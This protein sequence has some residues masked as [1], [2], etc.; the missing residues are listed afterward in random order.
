MEMLQRILAFLRRLLIVPRAYTPVALAQQALARWGDPMRALKRLL[1]ESNPSTL[2]LE[3]ACVLWGQCTL[4]YTPAHV[5]LLGDLLQHLPVAARAGVFC[6]AVDNDPV[7]L[8]TLLVSLAPLHLEGL[9]ALATTLK[10]Q[11]DRQQ[12]ND[13]L[14]LAFYQITPSYGIPLSEAVTSQMRIFLARA[15]YQSIEAL[16]R[17]FFAQNS[18]PPA[19]LFWTYITL[20]PPM[21]RSPKKQIA[22][23]RY[24]LQHYPVDHRIDQ[25]WQRLG[26][27]YMYEVGDY[28]EALHA[29]YKAEEHGAVVLQLQ[30]YRTGNWDALPALRQHPSDAFPPIVV[31]DLEVDPKPGAA[32]GTRVFEVAAVRYKG[33]TNLEEYHSYIHHDFLPAKWDKE[34]ATSRL[35]YA[36]SVETVAQ[37][38]RFFIGTAIVVGHNIQGFDALE[39]EAMGVTI[40]KEQMLDTLTLARWLHPDSLHHHLGLLCQFYHIPVEENSLHSALPDARV[41]ARLF[42]ALGESFVQRGAGFLTGIR[43]LVTPG[44]AFDRA[45]LQPRQ[46][47]ADPSL[48]WELDPRPVLP[49]SSPPC[50]ET[51]PV[52]RCRRPSNTR[53][54]RSSNTSISIWATISFFLHGSARS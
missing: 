30:S 49:A 12:C 23:L 47:P 20:A 33:R 10:E 29:Y 24:F 6:L 31:I 54:M 37:Q 32:K 52:P 21:A 41:C 1:R 43:A 19:D 36:P 3:A 11:W 46:L 18:L 9:S 7:R 26:D 40:A 50:A 15:D 35:R 48:S 27:L 17:A 42:H 2:T 14:A 39:L 45:I 34:T 8:T 16:L 13:D 5:E 53:V 28:Q 44:S 38:L 25:A 22:L 51:S 4:D